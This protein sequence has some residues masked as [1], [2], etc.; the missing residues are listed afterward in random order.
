M[1]AQPTEATAE[2]RAARDFLFEHRDDYDG[3]VAGFQWPRP[4]RLNWALE[5]FDVIAQ[6][7]PDRDALVIVEEDGTRGAWTYGSL[8]ARSDQVAGWLRENGVR[9][10]DRVIV[11]LGNQVELW[12]VILA[13]IKLGAVIIPA[14]TLL[15]T[16]DL[17]DRVRRGGARFVVARSVDAPTFRGV[18]G[19][20][21]RIAVGAP[22]LG[23]IEY[24][25]SA[26]YHQE[27]QLD[28]TTFA[29]DPLL[30]YFT[31]GTTALPKLVE[32]THV[33]YPIGHLSTMFWIGLQSQDVHL[34]ISSP[35]WAKHAWS[36]VFARRLHGVPLQLRAIRRGRP[37]A[38]HGRQSGQHVLCAA[39]GVADAH[40]GRPV[41][42]PD[43]A[44]GGRRGRR[45]AESGGYRAGAPGVAGDHQGRIRSDRDDAGGRQ[46][47]GP[48]GA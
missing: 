47:T 30:L 33:S 12:E 6:E 44:E 20:F 42:A 31:S 40:P 37:D 48:T 46:C 25:D 9:R 14:S 41:R 15:N 29:R 18:Q 27:L 35:G 10:G 2:L 11:M 45:A 36:N 3:A 34:N 4:G 5:W 21:I 22:V 1:T 39:H 32:H 28:G 43:A 16:P 19:T 17:Q 8:S 26:D 13:C 24:E 7:H 23:W 38:G